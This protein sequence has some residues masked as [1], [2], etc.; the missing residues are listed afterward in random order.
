M[1]IDAGRWIGLRTLCRK[2]I[3]RYLKVYHQT[4]IGP[5]VTG[6]LYLMIF[7]LAI[8]QYIGQIY[9]V[10]YTAFMASG[11]I[12][13]AVMQNAF[14]N[15]SSVLV[16]GKVTGSLI[17][18]LM[19]PFYPIDLMVGLMVGAVTRGILVGFLLWAAMALYVDFGYN[20]LGY[21]CLAVGIS[22]IVLGLL[23]ILT[24]IFSNSFDHMSMVTSYIIAPLSY[25]SGTFFTPDS[26]PQPLYL[27][28][29]L[30]PF[31]YMIDGIRYGLTGHHDGNLV[32]G[33]TYTGIIAV[34]LAATVYWLLKTG[35]R[36]R[37]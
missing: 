33:F 27:I 25:L 6:M 17:D 14:A 28:M 31:F 34:L 7:S 10:S 3:L 36:T 24:G 32:L 16:F 37:G 35:Y 4:L 11:L 29:Q 30:N 13:M 15:T 26:L 19:P 22:T 23:G 8:G 21:A 1:P 12:M 2:E 9:N 5:I 20:H 18:Y